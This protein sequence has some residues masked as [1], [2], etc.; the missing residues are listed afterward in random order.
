MAKDKDQKQDAKPKQGEKGAA[1]QQQK[2]QQ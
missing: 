1:P 2:P